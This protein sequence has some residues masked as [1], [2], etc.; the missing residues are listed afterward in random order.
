L[1]QLAALVAEAPEFVVVVRPHPNRPEPPA[2]L[3]AG[4]RLSPPGEDLTAL[5]HAVDYVVVETSTVGLEAAL[6]GKKV[7]TVCAR[8]YPPYA[9]YGLATDIDAVEA[10]PEA[11]RRAR[12][13]DRA[14]LGMPATGQSAAC[15]CAVIMDQLR[16]PGG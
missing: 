14:R 16:Q 11:L 8:G 13:P 12:T 5:L 4:F 6:L 3:P 1:Q 15:V 9:E 10:L 2:A 7:V